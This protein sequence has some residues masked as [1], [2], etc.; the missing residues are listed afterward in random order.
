MKIKTQT[1]KSKQVLEALNTIAS[2]L[3]D[4]GHKW[5][6]DERRLYMFA[7]RWLTSFY[8]EG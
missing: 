8:G 3:T 1:Q 4:Y 7:H 5:T 2:R 6:K